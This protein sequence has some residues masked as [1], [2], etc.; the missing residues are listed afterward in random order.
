MR[1]V[2]MEHYF[3]RRKITSNLTRYVAILLSL[4]DTLCSTSR[5]PVIPRK[6]SEALLK[7]TWRASSKLTGDSAMAW[8]T[9]ATCCD[10][11]VPSFTAPGGFIPE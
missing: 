8:V 1:A 11:I 9:L 2:K 7:P 3:S 10:M 4:T 6:V 5:N